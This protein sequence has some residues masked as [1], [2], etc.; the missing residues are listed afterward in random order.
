MYYSLRR[1]ALESGGPVPRFATSLRSIAGAISPASLDI[2]SGGKL[3]SLFSNVWK[4]R[5]GF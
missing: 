4:N 3:T 2:V 5:F 1:E